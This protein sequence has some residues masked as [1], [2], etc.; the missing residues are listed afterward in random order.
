MAVRDVF[1]SQDFE[2]VTTTLLD[3]M[4]WPILLVVSLVIAVLVPQTFKNTRSLEL[5]LFNAAPL[6]LLVLAESLCLLSGHFDLSIGAI[7]GFSA[8][9]T[10]ML[11]GT[12]PSCWG[13]I[14]NPFLAIGIILFVGGLIGLVNGVMIA[15]AGVNP[16]LQTLSFLIILEGAKIAINTQPASGL[17]NAYLYLGSHATT[18]IGIL[19]AVFI[20]A[21]LVIRFSAFGQAVY[22]VGSDTESARAVG[23]NTDRVIIAVFVL[24]GVLSGLAGLLITGYTTVVPPDVA[25]NMVFPAFAAAVIGGIS[26]FGGRGNITGALGG[27]LL[28]GVIQA[29]LTISGV[30]A[31]MVQM[32]N[33]IVLFV[34]ILLYNTRE[35]LRNQILTAGG[36]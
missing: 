5:V 1:P 33:G 30:P 3:N 27:V 8:M 28:L 19:F 18:S 36:N 11:L 14:A 24:S 23:V 22:A 9:F 29:A 16:F 20:I 17:P 21:S 31:S 34:A 32:A 10:G 25:E 2:G 15:K 4:I 6:G 7:A 35:E 26:L 12:C 13:L